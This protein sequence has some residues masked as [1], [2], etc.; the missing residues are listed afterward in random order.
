MSAHAAVA[1][2]QVP[3]S[4][5]ARAWR[6]D[7][8]FFL[9][10]ALVVALA[11]FIGFAPTYYLKGVFAAKPLPLL[12]H[13]HGALFTSWIVLLLVQT[14]LVAARRVDIHRRLGV[15]GGVLAGTMIVVGFT[16]AI[17]GLRRGLTIPG[18]PPAPV[19]FVIPFFDMVAFTGLVGAALYL[20]RRPESHKRL[21]LIATFAVLPAAFARIPGI[22]SLGPPGFFG[23]VDLL[24][25]ACWV[26][27]RLTR[28]R[29]HPAALWG[30]LFL[31]FSQVLRLIIGGTPVWLA[32]AGWLKG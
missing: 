11:V 26:Y 4:P 29:I 2:G 10:M 24:V 18:G 1:I 17:D 13:V 27:D 14:A 16:A 23:A 7:R 28:G 21:M 8:R 32:F 19:F 25:I 15:A 30:G 22:G 20:R 3:A 5:S 31:I 9:G 6:R 12:L